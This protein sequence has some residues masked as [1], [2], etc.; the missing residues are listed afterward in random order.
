MRIAEVPQCRAKWRWIDKA[1][2]EGK[3]RRE[4]KPDQGG[5]NESRYE[6]IARPIAIGLPV[7]T[8]FSTKR[9]A[10]MVR[11]VATIRR[12]AKNATWLPPTQPKADS[13]V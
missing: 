7:S 13:P 5:G 9:T 10:R 4:G 6:S 8:S 2:A 11:T 1:Q 12:T 3:K